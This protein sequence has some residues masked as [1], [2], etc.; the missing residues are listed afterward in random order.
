MFCISL[1][2]LVAV[3]GVFLL[4]KTKSNELGAFFKFSSYATIMAGILLIGASL[5]MCLG[6]CCNKKK[7]CSS[8]VEYCHSKKQQDGCSGATAKSCCK[9]KNSTCS[10]DA[11]SC[12]KKKNS[13]CSKDKKQCTKKE[14]DKE[15]EK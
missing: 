4:A 14:E 8:S 13:T 6:D 5:C 15:E 12:C 1:S 2:I 11:K 3:S 10:K 7:S 9:K